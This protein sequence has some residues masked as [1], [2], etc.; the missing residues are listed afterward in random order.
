MNYLWNLFLTYFALPEGML[1]IILNMDKCAHVHPCTRT[2]SSKGRSRSVCLPPFRSIPPCRSYGHKK[3]H[4]GPNKEPQQIAKQRTNKSS[5][6]A[7]ETN[8]GMSSGA[9]GRR[10]ARSEEMGALPLTRSVGASEGYGGGRGKKLRYTEFL[11][12]P[13]RVPV[14]SSY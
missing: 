2:H 8:G 9:R 11:D 14:L 12:S 3:C 6:W 10:G 1:Y 7:T 5:G 13:S 4:A